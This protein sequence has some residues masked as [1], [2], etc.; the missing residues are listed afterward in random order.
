MSLIWETWLP[1]VNRQLRILGFSLMSVDQLN[2]YILFISFE[3][4][5]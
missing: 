3:I 5:N 1:S 4:N 2:G